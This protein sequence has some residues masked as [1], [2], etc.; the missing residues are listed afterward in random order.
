MRRLRWIVPLLVVVALVPILLVMHGCA[1]TV[2]NRDPTGEVFPTVKGESLE[3]VDITLPDAFA[4]E[5]VVLLV[6]YRQGTQFDIDRWI[7][8]LI[9]AGVTARIVEVPT[10]PGLVTSL[11]SGWI[12]DGMRS[13]IP[14]EDWGAVVTLYGGAADPVAEFTGT[15]SG[16]NAR[17]L[18]LDAEG[19]VEWFTDRGYS[20]SQA[21]EVAALLGALQADEAGLETGG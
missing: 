20:A 3:K 19:G 9:Q 8:G 13:G 14:R 1:S 17:V 18:V 6:G 5:P 21:L 12:D 10:I 11:A 4:G 15:E 7:L 2:P 16:R